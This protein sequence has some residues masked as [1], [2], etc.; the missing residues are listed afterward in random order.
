MFV[1]SRSPA[2]MVTE[3]VK[4]P[5]L[6]WCYCRN[7]QFGQQRIW[8]ELTHL[9]EP[10]QC[11]IHRIGQ[12]LL[13]RVKIEDAQC[14]C[15]T[16]TQPLCAVNQQRIPREPLRC[17]DD[18]F[19][20]ARTRAGRDRCNAH[21]IEHDN[22]R[23]PGMGKI[24]LRLLR[25]ANRNHTPTLRFL[26]EQ[27]LRAEP[28]SDA[29]LKIDFR[30]DQALTGKSYAPLRSNHLALPASVYVLVSVSPPTLPIQAGLPPG[31]QASRFNSAI[32]FRRMSPRSASGKRPRDSFSTH[33]APP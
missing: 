8:H 31:F 27:A 23:V 4:E 12:I 14:G 19:C 9:T 22:D 15:R 5:A 1:K 11:K 13:L 20:M 18:G 32:S 29:Q 7:H 30:N 26:G 24:G 6:R 3:T 25:A 17:S 16:P 2:G 10:G 28:G 33:R 21:V